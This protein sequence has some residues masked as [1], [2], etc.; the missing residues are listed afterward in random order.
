MTDLKRSAQKASGVQS[1]RTLSGSNDAEKERDRGAEFGTSEPGTRGAD[2]DAD[3]S[4]ES[5]NEGYGHAPPE[6]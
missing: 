1:G 2:R 4:G 6:R 5:K 3:R